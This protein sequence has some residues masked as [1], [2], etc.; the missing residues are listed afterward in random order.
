M[1]HSA[2]IVETDKIGEGTNVWA[3]A[4][5]MSGAV[6]GENCNIGDH[7]FVEGGAEIGN[8]CTIKNNCLIWEGVTIAN[9][10]FVGPGVIFTNDQFPR[11]P[12]LDA[13]KVR[14]ESKEWLSPTLVEEGCSIGAGAVIC[15]GIKLGAYSMIGAGS[16]VTRDVQPHAL[17][18]GNPAKHSGFVCKCGKR[19]NNNSTTEPPVCIQCS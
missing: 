6:I 18:V 2:A 17:V 15:P 13:A 7:T 14:Y 10:V 5:I 1:I 11:S 19:A 3:Y 8:G 9:G 4:H 12:R 16:V